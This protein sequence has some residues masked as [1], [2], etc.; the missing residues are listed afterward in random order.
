[1]VIAS[2]VRQMIAVAFVLVV[3]QDMLQIVMNWDVDVLILL[4]NSTG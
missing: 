1:M 3:I 4:R 2:V